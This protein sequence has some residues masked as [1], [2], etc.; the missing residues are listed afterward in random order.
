VVIP[1]YNE[2]NFI[3]G[4]LESILKAKVNYKGKIEVIVVDDGIDRTS[5]IASEFGVKVIKGS[6]KGVS[7]A[8]N[9]GWKVAQGEVIVFLDADM[10]IDPNHFN[11]ITKNIMKPEVGGV[12]HHEVLHNKDSKIAQLNGLRLF[13]RQ[14]KALK[15]PYA[16][17]E[18]AVIRATRKEILKEVNGYDPQLYAYEDIELSTR[19]MSRM[20]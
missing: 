8:R 9:I 12:N 16:H 13:F 19:I 17:H 20:Q 5:N 1:T 15:N 11:E 18:G 4:C 14:Y 10:R 2:E 3:K 6:N 7:E